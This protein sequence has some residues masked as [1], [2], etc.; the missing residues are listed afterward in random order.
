MHIRVITDY[1]DSGEG[2]REI[3]TPQS[4]I[5]IVLLIHDSGDPRDETGVCGGIGSM[6][7]RYQFALYKGS[8]IDRVWPVVTF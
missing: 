1:I 8:P 7:V 5:E 6:S 4:V 3:L 2:S